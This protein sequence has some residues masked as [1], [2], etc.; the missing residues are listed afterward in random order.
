MSLAKDGRRSLTEH[1]AHCSRLH[2]E[3]EMV[4]C[5]SVWCLHTRLPFGFPLLPSKMQSRHSLL[6]KRDLCLLMQLSQL[7]QLNGAVS[8]H[9][10]KWTVTGYV[11]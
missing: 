8:A 7:G 1:G 2:A 11:G 10:Y 5:A 9:F 3:R 6:S 4:I